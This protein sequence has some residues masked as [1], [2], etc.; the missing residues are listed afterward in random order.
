M[1]ID[2][3]KINKKNAIVKNFIIKIVLEISVGAMK[4]NK[5]YISRAVETVS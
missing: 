1:I 2:V 5:K 4:T 3:E